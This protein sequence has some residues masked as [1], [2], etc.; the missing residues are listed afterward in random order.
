MKELYRFEI[1]KQKQNRKWVLT[2]LI[3]AVAYYLCSGFFGNTEL[4]TGYSKEFLFEHPVYLETLKSQQ[5]GIVDED[6]V[7]KWQQSYRDFVDTY[8]RSDEEIYA[9]MEEWGEHYKIEDILYDMEYSYLVIS[10]EAWD[11]GNAAS[12]QLDN[13]MY[14]GQNI[15]DLA[16]N[17]EERIKYGGSFDTYPKNLQAD[18][19]KAVCQY[20]TGR[21]IVAGYFLGWDALISMMQHLPAVLGI[22]LL[23]SFFH[24]FSDEKK[25]GMKSLFLVSKYGRKCAVTAKLIFVWRTATLCWLVFQAA[26]IVPV[27]AVFGLQG[28]GCTFYSPL[29]PS[30]YGFSCIR[31]YMVQLL[32]SYF[33]TM[34]FAFVICLLSCVLSGKLTL[35]A[36]AALVVGTSNAIDQY[37]FSEPAF[38]LWQKLLVLMPTQLIG[39]FNTYQSYQGYAIG[40]FVIRLPVASYLALILGIAFCLWG[41][42]KRGNCE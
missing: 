3:L 35:L 13:I 31:Y 22:T 39:A 37:M 24:L 6:F 4:N 14:E 25:Y 17:P 30:V 34:F 7:K 26:A 1:E 33:G 11:A 9:A 19:E 10:D 28:A 40:K 18:F 32:V 21:K 29:H 38:T 16:E 12:W 5:S 8:R 36:G 23:I 15:V 42:Y 20:M 41:I 2:V 27:A